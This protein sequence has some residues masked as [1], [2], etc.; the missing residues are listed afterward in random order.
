MHLR[1]LKWWTNTDGEISTCQDHNPGKIIF[2]QEASDLLSLDPSNTCRWAALNCLLVWVISMF[3]LLRFPNGLRPSPVAKLM[4]SQWQRKRQCFPVRV[5][6]PQYPVSDQGTHFS[7]RN[8]QA[9]M[10]SLQTSGIIIISITL[11]QTRSRKLMRFLKFPN[12]KLLGLSD[13][14]YCPWYCGLIRLPHLEKKNW[15]NLIHTR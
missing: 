1:W 6:L 5:Y 3:L 2:Y 10:K 7:G 13:L 11:N 9:F 8:F 12:L 14:T 15:T 4:S